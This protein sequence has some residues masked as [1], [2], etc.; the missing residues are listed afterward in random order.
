MALSQADAERHRV[1]SFGSELPC[2]SHALTGRGGAEGGRGGA[3]GGRGGA[4][5]CGVFTY[6][7]ITVTFCDKN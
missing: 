4:A 6:Q 3:K 5:V 1:E 2:W 7:L